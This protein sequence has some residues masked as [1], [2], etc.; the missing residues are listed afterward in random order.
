MRSRVRPVAALHANPG[1]GRAE[2]QGVLDEAD[3]RGLESPAVAGS[4]NVVVDL[5]ID[6]HVGAMSPNRRFLDR[7][8]HHTVELY[9]RAFEPGGSKRRRR[10]SA[11]LAEVYRLCGDHEIELIQ[12]SAAYSGGSES[13][14]EGNSRG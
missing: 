11:Q 3:R 2:L 7:L 9:D 8:A 12:A 13:S 1:V 6:L 10:Q 5:E 14:F 4:A